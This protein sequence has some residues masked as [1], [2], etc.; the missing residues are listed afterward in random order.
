MSVLAVTPILNVSDVGAS[1]DWFEQLGWRRG[2]TWN[3]GGLIE[4][5]AVDDSNGPAY[6]G[7]VRTGDSEIFLCREGQG[8][9]GTWVS[10]WVESPADVDELHERAS[11]VGAEVTYPPTDERWGA[12]EFHLRHPDGHIFRVS[13]PLREE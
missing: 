5:A 4:G 8:A 11:Q 1:I 6:F 12:R 10:W 9:P 13:A 3:D 2:F 7:S